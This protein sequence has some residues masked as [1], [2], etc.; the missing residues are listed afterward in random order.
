MGSCPLQAHSGSLPPAL[1]QASSDNSSITSLCLREVT[2]RPSV[3]RLPAKRARGIF[4]VNDGIWRQRQGIDE[5]GLRTI[6]SHDVCSRRPERDRRLPYVVAIWPAALSAMRGDVSSVRSKYSHLLRDV[7]E[8]SEPSVVQYG[9]P[10]DRA[11]GRRAIAIDRADTE[12]L[13]QGSFRSHCGRRV[14]L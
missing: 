7:I 11:E 2:A 3:R 14:T 13:L 1:S 5:L 9:E 10:A 6:D 8:Y 12:Y 4:R